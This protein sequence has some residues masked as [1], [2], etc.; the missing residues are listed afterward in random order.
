LQVNW[1]VLVGE[2]EDCVE[3]DVDEPC[4]EDRVE[5]VNPDEVAEKLPLA[6]VGAKI[7]KLIVGKVPMS[8]SSKPSSPTSTSS[9]PSWSNA[10]VHDDGPAWDEEEE[11]LELELKLVVEAEVVDG[12]VVLESLEVLCGL[13]E[14]SV[15]SSSGLF[16]GLPSDPINTGGNPG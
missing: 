6:P 11:E 5:V 4:E 14:A 16:V 12:P 1:P 9:S 3:D 2:T 13:V 15:G 10:R 7:E 8:I